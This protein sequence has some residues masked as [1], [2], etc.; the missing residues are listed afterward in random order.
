NRVI[1]GTRGDGVWVSEDFGQS[2]KKPSY[3]R[4]G[5]GKVR[6]VTIDPKKPNRLYAGTE[7]IDVFVSDDLGQ[8]WE[9]LVSIWDIPQVASITYPVAVVEPHVRFIA[10]DPA[11]T[12]TVYAALQVGSIAKTSN[13]GSTWKLQ[14]R[15]VDCD[16]HTIVIDPQDTKNIFVATGGHD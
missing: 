9:R 8:N 14:D 2:W 11:A 5:P 1:A 13:G 10:I 3:G 6:S 12:D 15:D 4:P 16:V 7:P